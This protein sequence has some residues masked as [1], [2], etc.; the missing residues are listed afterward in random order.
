MT[1]RLRV[2]N[3]KAIIDTCDKFSHH[4]NLKNLNPPLFNLRVISRMITVSNQDL[5]FIG[6]LPLF[7]GPK[8]TSLIF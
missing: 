2:N 4:R 8:I 3:N 6:S 1:L 7:Y 5:E